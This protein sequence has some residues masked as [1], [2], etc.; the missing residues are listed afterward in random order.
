MPDEKEL[1]AETRRGLRILADSTKAKVNAGAARRLYKAA[2]SGN[3]DDYDKAEAAFDSLPLEQ[4]TRI[5][6]T[7]ETKATTV[8]Q[9]QVQRKTAKNQRA[10]TRDPKS[11]K[12]SATSQTWDLG[13]TQDQQRPKRISHKDVPRKPEPR[14]DRGR[15]GESKSWEWQKL[16]NDPTVVA[17]R[18]RKPANELEALR[19]EILRALKD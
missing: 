10:E 2:D 12:Q 16:P 11:E 18:K 15:D 8:R 6:L 1:D 4:R 7:A 5:Q 9:T 17:S 14:A 13:P 19:Q 3:L